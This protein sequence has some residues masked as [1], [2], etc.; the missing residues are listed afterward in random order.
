MRSACVPVVL[1]TVRMPL[2]LND[3]AII[4]Q[5]LDLPRVPPT[6]IRI[7]TLRSAAR[8]RRARTRRKSSVAA[9]GSARATLESASASPPVGIRRFISYWLR[10]RGEL[11][12]SRE[13]R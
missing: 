3:A 1:A 5:T 10:R 8:N 9:A 13:L 2:C 7:G 12:G 11:S 4:R 6:W